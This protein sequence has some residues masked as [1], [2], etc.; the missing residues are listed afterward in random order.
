[1]RLDAIPELGFVEPKPQHIAV[2]EAIRLA[3]ALGRYLPGERL[4][5]E[6]DLA[7]SLGVGRMT[8]RTAIRLLNDEGLLLTSR[9]R[10]GGST[11]AETKQ[12]KDRKREL[13]KRARDELRENYEFRLA[14]EPVA[15][16]LCAERATKLERSTISQ[17]ANVTPDS[18]VQY[19][20]LDSRFHLAI[21]EAC[22]NGPLLEAVR[23]ARADFFIWADAVWILSETLS[24]ETETSGEQHLAITNAI[25]ESDA[26]QAEQNMTMHLEWSRSSFATR[27]QLQP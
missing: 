22:G 4:P 27:L 11:I 5:S 17:L 13:V 16:R 2:A 15:A 1:M 25:N 3:I 9:G 18:L 6:R 23:Q 26:T 10:S 19:R 14:I 8:L 7:A 24:D 12:R 20:A 21:G